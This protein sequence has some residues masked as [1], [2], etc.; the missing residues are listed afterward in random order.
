MIRETIAS[1]I[2]SDEGEGSMRVVELVLAIVAVI[3]AGIL[4]FVR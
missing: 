1:A 4:A 2:R 3:A